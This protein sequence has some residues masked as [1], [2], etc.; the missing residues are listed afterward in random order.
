MKRAATLYVL[1]LAMTGCGGDAVEPPPPPQPFVVAFSDSLRSVELFPD[2]ASCRYVLKVWAT[3]GTQDDFA[4][5]TGGVLQWVDV[6][7]GQRIDD[8]LSATELLDY[9]G[10]DRVRTGQTL[11]ASR[12]A[13]WDRPFKLHY[14]VRHEGP[15][16]SLRSDDIW[17]DCSTPA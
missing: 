2:S 12:I 16:G 17:V 7:S 11:R 4:R 10:A 1:V 3:G 8:E 6:A 9:F 15:D 5:W 13:R 14:V